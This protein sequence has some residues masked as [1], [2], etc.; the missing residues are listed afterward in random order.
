MYLIVLVLFACGENSESMDSSIENGTVLANET[1]YESNQAERESDFDC[2]IRYLD[3]V[4]LQKPTDCENPKPMQITTGLITSFAHGDTD[5][6]EVVLCLDSL[7]GRDTEF[8]FNLGTLGAM[9]INYSDSLYALE[10]NAWI[11][12][13]EKTLHNRK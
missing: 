13:Y 8:K 9:I 11:T 7:T 2:H 5:L 6:M 10:R 12:E 3:A 1:T 4:F